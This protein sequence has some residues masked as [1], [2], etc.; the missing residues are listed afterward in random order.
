MKFAKD[1]VSLIGQK[2]TEEIY[3]IIAQVGENPKDYKVVA[4]PFSL[5][6]S[7]KKPVPRK[8]WQAIYNELSIQG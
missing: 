7:D 1:T 3:R 8:I 2:F 6:R 4:I 5:E